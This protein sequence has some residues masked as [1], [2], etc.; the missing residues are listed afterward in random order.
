MQD[1]NFVRFDVNFKSSWNHSAEMN[2]TILNGTAFKRISIYKYLGFNDIMCLR[3]SKIKTKAN[4][5]VNLFFF[6]FLSVMDYGDISY[7]QSP[8]SNF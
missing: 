2:I 6:F 8:L 1:P 3:K 5:S 4:C 7:M